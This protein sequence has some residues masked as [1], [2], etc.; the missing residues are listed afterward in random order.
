MYIG[1]TGFT[2]K[3]Q[4]RTALSRVPSDADRLFMV[5]VLASAK[6]IQGLPAT[7]PKR[8]P[9]RERIADIFIN[10]WRALNLVHYNTRDQSELAAQ[11]WAALQWGGVDCD[12]LQLNIVLPDPEVIRGL[13]RSKPETTIVL[14]LNRGTMRVLG[15]SSET[16]ADTLVDRYGALVDHILVD[17]SGGSGEALVPHE[18]VAHL[19]ALDHARTRHGHQFGLCVAGG[20]CADNLEDLLVPV[21]M[22][23]PSFGIDAEG[24]VRTD[25]FLDDEKV[26]RYIDAAY[27]FFAGACL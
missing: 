7:N 17:A 24:R 10:D 13:K 6:T 18:A 27:R 25:D 8:Y 15:G 22:L 19:I 9:A 12:G 2:D 26:G 21:Q 4:V 16:I 11:L 5:G 20:L 1:V 14:Q 23:V 3:A